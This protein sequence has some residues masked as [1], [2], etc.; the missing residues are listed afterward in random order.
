M[1]MGE[2]NGHFPLREKSA[3][4]A[5]IVEAV[6]MLFCVMTRPGG[7]GNAC[8]VSVNSSHPLIRPLQPLCMWSRACLTDIS[9]IEESD[10][11]GSDDD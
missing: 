11:G 2:Y 10:F 9:T 6:F 7:E 1:S 8:S 3:V 5:I 4:V